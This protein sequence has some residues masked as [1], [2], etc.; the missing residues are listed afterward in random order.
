[1]SQSLPNEFSSTDPIP[2]DPSI[3]YDALVF[4]VCT[5]L[6]VGAF[7]DGLRTHIAD[8]NDYFQVSSFSDSG[9]YLCENFPIE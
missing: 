5:G 6:T 8:L 1:M 4:A 7:F 3:L 9:E 2:Q